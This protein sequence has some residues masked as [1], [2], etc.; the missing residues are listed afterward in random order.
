VFDPTGRTDGTAT[1]PASANKSVTRQPARDPRIPNGGSRASRPSPLNRVTG[2]ASGT[3]SPPGKLCTI[4]RLSSG[5]GDY[6]FAA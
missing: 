6:V 2:S 4:E 1:F 5:V 3:P